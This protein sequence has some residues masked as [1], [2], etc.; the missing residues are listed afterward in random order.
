MLLYLIYDNSSDEDLC[1]KC[2][3]TL[4]DAHEA[5]NSLGLRSAAIARLR[6]AAIARLCQRTDNA[7][8]IEAAGGKCPAQA[9]TAKPTSAA[10]VAATSPFIN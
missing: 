7:K 5:L 2:A 3:G 1:I 10:E 9:D 8:A 6:S 4:E